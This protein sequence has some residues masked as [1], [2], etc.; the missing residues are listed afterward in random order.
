MTY[1]EQIKHPEWQ[2]KRL[3]VLE[4]NSFTCEDCG[5]T[6]KQLHVH[7]PYYK[8]FALIW[9]YD[10][11]ELMCLCNEC[12][13]NYH[14]VTNGIKAMIAT[15]NLT[16]LSRLGGYATALLGRDPKIVA[17]YFNKGRS[18]YTGE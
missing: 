11:S 10:V 4:A 16:Q 8:K 15:M 3:E 6:E 1:Q 2:K 5:A 18:D 12:H 14:S 17:P 7:H 13:E 9:E